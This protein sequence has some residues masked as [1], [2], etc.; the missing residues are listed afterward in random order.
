MKDAVRAVIYRFPDENPCHD[1]G[2]SGGEE[3][4]KATSSGGDGYAPLAMT[5]VRSR[6]IAR[7]AATKQSPA[8][9]MA[10]L[11]LP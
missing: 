7:S 9:G 2:R 4:S 6:V 3:R 5:G 11:R 8:A 1:N 10:G